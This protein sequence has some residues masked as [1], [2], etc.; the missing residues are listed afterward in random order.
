MTAH[1]YSIRAPRARVSNSPLVEGVETL[2]A[3]DLRV[4]RVQRELCPVLTMHYDL[5]D[6]V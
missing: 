5:Y 2:V 3:A 6:S 4:F 1:A